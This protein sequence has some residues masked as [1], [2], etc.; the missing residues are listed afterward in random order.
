MFLCVRMC[1]D[2]CSVLVIN[3]RVTNLVVHNDI[4]NKQLFFLSLSY[5]DMFLEVVAL[6]LEVTKRKN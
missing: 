3:F 2:P 5:L 1:L 6:L 4:Y